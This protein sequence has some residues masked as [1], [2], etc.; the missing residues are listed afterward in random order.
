MGVSCDFC[1]STHTWYSMSDFPQNINMWTTAASHH[2][3]SHGPSLATFF[4]SLIGYT[5]VT[6][7]NMAQNNS[8]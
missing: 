2:P 7:A 5:S 3:V 6:Y 1:Q 8:L 4:H